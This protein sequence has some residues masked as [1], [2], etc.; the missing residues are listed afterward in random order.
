MWINFSLCKDH[1]EKEWKGFRI[2]KLNWKRKQTNAF[3]I[4]KLT[5]HAWNEDVKF[6]K[7]NVT[8]SAAGPEYLEQG[9]RLSMIS[10]FVGIELFRSLELPLLITLV[11]DLEAL[12]LKFLDGVRR[13]EDIRLENLKNKSVRSIPW[14]KFWPCR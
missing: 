14:H 10:G 8:G 9:S 12:L 5:G 3:Y 11:G 1:A 4:P 2:R 7:K 13:G 6:Y